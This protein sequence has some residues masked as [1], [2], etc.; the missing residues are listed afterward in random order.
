MPDRIK[1]KSKSVSLL[2]LFL[3][4]SFISPAYAKNAHLAAWITI[5]TK[6]TIIRFLKA[7]DLYAFS[8]SIDFDPKSWELKQLFSDKS[9]D[10]ILEEISAKVDNLYERVQEILDMR[11]KSPKVF[12]TVYPDRKALDQA[13]YEI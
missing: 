11:K 12:I 10:T 6:Y 13:H 1:K 9:P 4:F 8:N 3:Y 7:E 5:E 2:T